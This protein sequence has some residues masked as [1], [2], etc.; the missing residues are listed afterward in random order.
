MQLEPV[1]LAG[2]DYGRAVDRS[3]A[4]VWPR[5]DARHAC[6]RRQHHQTGLTIL[7]AAG[8][9]RGFSRLL[10]D[11]TLEIIAQYGFWLTA[12]F[13][14]GIITGWMTASPSKH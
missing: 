11:K 6:R 7:A 14:V 9:A 12:A 2:I 5:A 8:P 1:D 13:V 3:G 10:G 4:V